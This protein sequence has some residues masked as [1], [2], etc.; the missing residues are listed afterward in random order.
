MCISC[1]K[2]AEKAYRS[3]CNHFRIVEQGAVIVNDIR[4]LRKSQDI[5]C[6]HIDL[7]SKHILD[8]W[9]VNS[10]SKLPTLYL[11]AGDST[12]YMDNSQKIDKMTVVE[13]PDYTGWSIFSCKNEGKYI[14]SV[15]FLK[16]E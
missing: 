11:L 5:V 10:D 2:S 7:H 9:C 14:V 4:V 3:Q 16:N 15:V 12:L 8:A 1:V 6:M 13:F